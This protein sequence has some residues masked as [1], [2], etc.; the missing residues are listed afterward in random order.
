MGGIGVM[1][2]EIRITVQSEWI[3]WKGVSGILCDRKCQ[4]E[5][6][7]KGIQDCC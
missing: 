5:G 2:E 3:H 4:F 7:A 1:D 6:Q